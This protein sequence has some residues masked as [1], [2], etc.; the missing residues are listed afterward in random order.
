MRHIVIKIYRLQLDN[1]NSKS[2]ITIFHC[3]WLCYD[4]HCEVMPM[5]QVTRYCIMLLHTIN[6]ERFK[7]LI[8]I[9]RLRVLHGEFHFELEDNPAFS[10]YVPILIFCSKFHRNFQPSD[11]KNCRFDTNLTH[12]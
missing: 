1:M 8:V 10:R 3:S 5:F 9:I 2:G 11:L 7:H 6:Y 4:S 12:F